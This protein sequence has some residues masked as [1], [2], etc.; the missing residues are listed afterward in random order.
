MVSGKNSSW[1]KLP[2]A[3]TTGALSRRAGC[4]P[5]LARFRDMVER[6]L[7]CEFPVPPDR[8]GVGREAAPVL[9]VLWAIN[10][11]PVI[12]V[13]VYLLLAAGIAVFNRASVRLL[14]DILDG[15]VA[16]VSGTIT[17]LIYSTGERTFAGTV[18][19]TIS[20]SRGVCSAQPNRS[21]SRAPS[22]A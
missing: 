5:L 6:G 12:Q 17:I 16:E 9:F 7:R 10:Q 19:A 22:V 3:R 14:L 8:F 2:R 11:Q 18:K 15:R 4:R 1:R 21:A 13:V 20:S